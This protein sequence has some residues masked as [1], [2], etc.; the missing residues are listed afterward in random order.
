MTAAVRVSAVGKEYRRYPPDRPRTLK[1]A[2]LRGFRDVRGE[3]FWAL[4]DVSF[5]VERGRTLGVIGANGAG[6]STLLRLLSAVERPDQGAIEIS[7]RVGAIL[8]IGVGFHPDLTGRENALLASVVAGLTRRDALARL[9]DL[10]AFAQ[11]E[12]FIDSPLRTYS[13][14]MSARLAFAIASHIDPEVLLVDEALSV[15]DLAFQRRCMERIREFKEAGVTSVVVSHDPTRIRDLCD[16]VVWLHE[17]RVVAKGPP[18][19]VTAR[20]VSSNAEQTRRMTPKDIPVHQTL[21]GVSLRIHENR[22]GTQEASISSVRVLDGWG[23][24]CSAVSSGSAVAVEVDL[25]APPAIHTFH[26]GVTLRRA[27][28]AVCLDAATLITG[29]DKPETIRVE[30]DRLDVAAGQYAFDVG[31]YSLDW[32]RT[33][34]Y[35]YGVYP[36][37]VVGPAPGAGFMAPPMAWVVPPKDA[38]RAPVRARE[39]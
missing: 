20:Y 36:L 22:F 8:E 2:A 4:R 6:K 9:P 17:G 30:I 31:L 15:G 32:S 10:V 34:D 1:E 3:R 26:I 33:Y 21:G 27:D 19:E 25:S 13:T 11:L 29:E 7:G 16:E 5:D 35:H 37:A 23:Q 12:D 24:R 18:M 14:G 39:R 28:D 38:R